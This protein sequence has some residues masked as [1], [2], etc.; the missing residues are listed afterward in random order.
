MLNK[1]ALLRA[2]CDREDQKVGMIKNDFRK[3]F[4][5]EKKLPNLMFL[6]ICSICSNFSFKSAKQIF[7]S[8][9][10][11]YFMKMKINSEICKINL[12]N[13]FFYF[14]FFLQHKQKKIYIKYAPPCS[15]CKQKN[16]SCIRI[17][18]KEKRNLI[19]SLQQPLKQ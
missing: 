6:K 13:K 1:Y 2:S 9:V 19:K 16:Y 17:T 18:I 12:Q 11:F 10:Y 15:I 7:K 3:I 4:D 5:D 8:F 14:L